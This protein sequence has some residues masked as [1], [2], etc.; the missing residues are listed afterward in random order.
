M[1]SCPR[2]STGI[3]GLIVCSPPYWGVCFFVSFVCFTLYFT[4][5]ARYDSC[6]DDGDGGCYSDSGRAV[7]VTDSLDDANSTW[8]RWNDDSDWDPC[9][10]WAVRRGCV[11]SYDTLSDAY[12][13]RAVAAADTFDCALGAEPP[14]WWSGDQAY[15]P[16]PAGPWRW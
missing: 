1:D 4:V 16:Q 15:G 10:F 12:Q 9:N 6:S 14:S 3:L 2:P 7:Y 11:D 13:S 5:F 8:N